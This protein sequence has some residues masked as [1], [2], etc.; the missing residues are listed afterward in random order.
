MLLLLVVVVLHSRFE[1]FK[2]MKKTSHFLTQYSSCLVGLATIIF[3]GNTIS[4]EVVADK[5]G[6][7]GPEIIHSLDFASSPPVISNSPNGYLA[8]ISLDAPNDLKNA[9]IRAENLYLEGKAGQADAPLSFVLHGPEVALFFKENYQQNKEMVD[10]A[11]RLTAF[12]VVE[13]RVC[14]TRM[15]VLGRDRSELVPFV[16]TVPFGPAEINR[17]LKTEK[18][19]YF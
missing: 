6:Y 17:L 2:S 9:L 3:S 1:C 11:A 14:E 13:V 15:G 10:I 12:K 19:V 7:P 8:R 4:S 18:Y 16:G 5:P